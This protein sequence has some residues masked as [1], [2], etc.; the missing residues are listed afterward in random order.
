MKLRRIRLKPRSPWRTPW[1]ADTL[2]G[3][4]CTTA[5]RVYGADFLRDRLIGPMLA[6]KP[7][8]VLSDAFPGDVLP[9]PVAVRLAQPPP[10]ADRKAIKRG[11]GVTREDFLALRAGADGP[12]GEVR[13]P[14]DRLLPDSAVFCNEITRHNTLARDSD[15]PLEDGGLFARPD[16][17]LQERRRASPNSSAAALGTHRVQESAPD[18]GSGYLTIYFRSVDDA[19]TELLLELLYELSLVGF[20]ADVA[21]GRGQFEL[22]GEPEDAGE[23]DECPPGANGIIILSTFQPGPQDPTDGLWEAFPKFA[24]L[25]PGLGVSDVRKNTLIMFRPGACFRT[26][27]ALPFLGRALPMDDVLPACVAAELR[28]RDVELVHPAFGLSIPIRLPEAK[29]CP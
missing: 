16:I 28:D 15:A 20:G 18:N 12:V 2:T 22:L 13:V 29:G 8:F 17:L 5:A 27:P 19:A 11:R 7:P 6:G 14:W 3:A 23:L 25:G 10:D 24:K 4:L 26:D 9:V 1:Q 21:T